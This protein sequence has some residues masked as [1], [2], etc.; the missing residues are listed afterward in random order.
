MKSFPPRARSR[1][2]GFTLFELLVGFGLLTAISVGTIAFMRQGL[3]MYYMDRARTLVN[4]DI[5]TFTQQLDT[6]AVTA[7]F[8]LIYPDFNTRSVS[9]VDASVA[10]G[11]VGDFLV[12]VYTDPAQSAQGISMITRIVGYYREVTDST[13]N[14]GP[15]HRFDTARAGWSPALPSAGVNVTSAAMYQILNTYVTGSASSYPIVTQLAQGL[16]TTTVSG[17]TTATP[18]LFYNRLNRSVMV[19]T[20]ISESLSE[21]NATSQTGNTYNFTVS[22]RG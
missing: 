5:R 17:Q 1:S 6:D 20:Q 16:A 21:R 15:V 7:N 12:F 9:S 10:D 2:A 22:P 11:Q 13:L 14:V 19:D 8:F 3:K 4:R 18:A